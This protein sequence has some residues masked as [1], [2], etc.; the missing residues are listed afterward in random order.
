MFHLTSRTRHLLLGLLLILPLVLTLPA[1]LA[2]RLAR[3]AWAGAL[4]WTSLDCPSGGPAQAIAISPSFAHD[5]LVIAGGGRDYGRGSWAGKGIFRSDDRGLTWISRSGPSNGAVFDVAFSANWASDG[6]ALAGLWQGLWATTDAG[7]SWHQMSSM[8]TGGPWT[9]SSVAISPQ[10]ATDR[11]LLAG[12]SYGIIF[13]T[14]DAG[15]TWATIGGPSSL[16]RV[17]FAPGAG[18]VALAASAN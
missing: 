15:A 11:T 12:G 6:F 10:F 16:R 4:S 13:R 5:G 14:T 17:V 8:E 3:D 1:L 7:A 18:A 2:G 9:V